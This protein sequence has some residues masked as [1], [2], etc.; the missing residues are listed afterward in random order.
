MT[1]KVLIKVIPLIEVKLFEIGAENFVKKRLV[2]VCIELLQNL[3]FHSY[4]DKAKKYKIPH[5][6]AI[7]FENDHFIVVSS[8]LLE[9]KK[10]LQLKDRLVKLNSI[11]NEAVKFLYNIVIKQTYSKA[12]KGGAGLGLLDMRR[13]TGYPLDFEFELEDKRVSRFFLK[14]KIPNKGKE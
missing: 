12:A 2:N 8:N 1:N 5:E 7:V 4:N 14:V 11:D 10:A 3:M 9:N 6:F 13:K